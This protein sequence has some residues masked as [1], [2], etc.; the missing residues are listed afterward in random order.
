M[1]LFMESY[2]YHIEEGSTWLFPFTGIMVSYLNAALNA[3]I[4]APFYGSNSDQES[5]AYAIFENTE[6]ACFEMEDL[7]KKLDY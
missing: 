1:E 6:G 7:A 2:K 4:S 3:G 5:L